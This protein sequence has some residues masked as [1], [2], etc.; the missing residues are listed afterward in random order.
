MRVRSPLH[1]VHADIAARQRALAQTDHGALVSGLVSASVT[2]RH[3]ADHQR[4]VGYRFNRALGL[5]S[6]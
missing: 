6:S 4:F 5:A 3:G 2:K 1:R